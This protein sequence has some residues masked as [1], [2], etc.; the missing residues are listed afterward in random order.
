MSSDKEFALFLRKFK[1]LLFRKSGRNV[2]ISVITENLKMTVV[3]IGRPEIVRKYGYTPYVRY[4]CK[5]FQKENINTFYLLAGGDL[6]IA[7]TNQ[8]VQR[9]TETEVVK[10]TNRYEGESHHSKIGRCIL[11]R[12]EISGDHNDERAQVKRILSKVMEECPQKEI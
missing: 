8:V 5:A 4:I 1:Q 10:E 12:L 6:N 9:L 3:L 7:V 2:D 11:I